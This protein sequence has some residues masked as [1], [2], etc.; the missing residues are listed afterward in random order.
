MTAWLTMPIALLVLPLPNTVAAVFPK[1]RPMLLLL[2]PVGSTFNVAVNT[3]RSPTI[4]ML[5]VAS[6]TALMP[7]VPTVAA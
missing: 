4:G 1:P 5:E 7:G 3:V 2:L 6:T